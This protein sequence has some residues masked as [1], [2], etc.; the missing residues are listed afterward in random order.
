[1]TA[2]PA[3][4]TADAVPPA[5]AK[6]PI[7]RRFPLG[8]VILL[9]V[10]LIVGVAAGV[11]RLTGGTWMIISSPSMGEANPVGSLILN[12]PVQI[13]DLHVGDTITFTPPGGETHTHRVVAIAADG[14]HTRGDANAADDPYA[15]T[16]GEI[17]GR[18]VASFFA[19][20]WLVKAAPLLM[21]GGLV[22]WF[23]TARWANN[24]W[25][26][27]I[28][29]LGF[30]FLVSLASFLLRPFV[31]QMLIDTTRDAQGLHAAVISTGLLP[32]RISAPTG[33]FVD[34]ID[35]RLRVLTTQLPAKTIGIDLNSHIHM[36]FW[37]WVLM[38][39]IWLTP[40]AVSLSMVGW[41]RHSDHSDHLD[42][43]GSAERPADPDP[44]VQFDTLR[45]MLKP[46]LARL[47]ARAFATPVRHRRRPS[48]R[49]PLLAFL[50][51]GLLGGLIAT[52]G[53]TASAFTTRITNTAD[54]V[55]SNPFFSC[56]LAGNNSGAYFE[57]PLTEALPLVGTAAADIS[58]NN[59]PGTYAGAPGHSTSNPCTR[60]TAGS[61]A[62][63]IVGDYVYY[64]TS[65]NSPATFTIAI[66]F[67]TT[68]TT[69]GRLMGF[70]GSLTGSSGNYDRHLFLSNAGNVVFGVYNTAIH[71][72][73]SPLTYRDGNWHQAVATF[74]AGTGMALYVDGAPAASDS[75]TTTAQAFTGYWRVGWDNLANWGTFMPSTYTFTGNLAYAAMYTSVL[76]APQ[77]A[78]IYYA[79]K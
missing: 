65:F 70:S 38:I 24:Q 62:T 37:W 79:G 66:W 11:W 64:P 59:R 67:K 47:P 39:A 25:R 36:S 41:A 49:R 21:I 57:Y 15:L 3:A 51:V 53:T 52:T 73:N 5:G 12:R 56:R 58:G 78:A 77:V 9:G 34:L 46:E 74:S 54:T 29:V 10:L 40:L 26:A 14:V 20:G 13:A 31:N 28:R 23:A 4:D 6:H 60:D 35:G 76:T 68:T 69:G 27:P 16:Q 48:R 50:A 30:S 75:S 32:I 33:G 2:L 17:D 55:G 19:L 61:L 1:M 63:G 18:V 8:G 7:R 43:P 71:T 42:P 45:S 72:I 22:I 44:T